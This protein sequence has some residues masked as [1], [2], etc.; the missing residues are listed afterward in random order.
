MPVTGKAMSKKDKETQTP[1]QPGQGPEGA[2]VVEPAAEA[3]ARLEAQLAEVQDRY[4][5][6]AAEFDNYKKRM[7]S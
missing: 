7:M 4:L 1:R 6:L 3:V 2:A 5:R